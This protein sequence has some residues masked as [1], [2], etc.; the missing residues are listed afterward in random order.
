MSVGL[1]QKDFGTALGLT[2]RQVRNLGEKGLPSDVDGR[3]RVYGPAAFQWYVDFKV[4][5]ERRKHERTDRDALEE[6]RLTHQIREAKVRADIAEGRAVLVED[7]LAE[8]DDAVGVVRAEVLKLP[9]RF[10]GDVNPEDPAAGEDVLEVVAN[11]LLTSLQEAL[12]PP[13][14][15]ENAA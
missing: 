7:A 8:W 4:D 2:S 1:S 10:G 11:D 13:K 5:E 12:T 3:T 15:I 6:E 14:E 9:T